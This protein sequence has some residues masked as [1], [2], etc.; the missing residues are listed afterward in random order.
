[1]PIPSDYAEL[2]S[3]GL[4]TRCV[5]ALWS[6]KASSPGVHVVLPDGRMDLIVRYRSPSEDSIVDIHPAIIGPSSRTT[7]VLVAEGDHFL[8][9]RYRAGWGG[10]SLGVDAPLL[11]D[12]ALHGTEAIGVLGDDAKALLAAA[13]PERLRKALV[14]VAHRRARLAKQRVAEDTIAAIDL[15]HL[16][17]GRM[18]ITEVALATRVPERTLRRHM[19]HAVGLS[20]KTFSGVLRFQ[21]TIRLLAASSNCSLTLAQAALEGGYS[22]QAHMTREFRRYGDFTPGARPPVVLGSLPVGH[23]A[24]TFNNVAIG[25]L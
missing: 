8:G 21:R 16:T 3:A 19:A 20:F 5:E 1:M 9:L 2:S 4:D 6:F 22:D 24:E 7:R 11:R 14:E 10:I 17:G 13:T 18:A 12:S 23:L 25:A 15:L